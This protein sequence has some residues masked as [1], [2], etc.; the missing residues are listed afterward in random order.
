MDVIAWDEKMDM[1]VV[2]YPEECWHCGV[3]WFEC[4]KRA[5]DITYPASLW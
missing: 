2:V 4:P 1:P 3:C 5:I